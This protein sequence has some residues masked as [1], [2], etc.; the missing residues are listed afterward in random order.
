MKFNFESSLKWGAQCA[1]VHTGWYS[2][3]VGTSEF[4]RVS[5]RT[6]LALLVLSLSIL[7]LSSISAKD[8]D[9]DDDGEDKVEI[10]I[11][12][13]HALRFGTVASSYDGTGTATVSPSGTLTTT[14]YAIELGGNSRAAE[15]KVKGPKNG[16]VLITLPTTATVTSRSGSA[17][18]TNFV[19]NPPAGI[20][21]LDHKG[22]LTVKLGR[23]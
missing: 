19:S 16:A 4:L 8:R 9:D 11:E 14:G 20:A 13:K 5:K 3:R 22:K 10:K 7:P 15:Y 6:V 21:Q 23:R 12:E 17:T 1:C 18:L 2:D